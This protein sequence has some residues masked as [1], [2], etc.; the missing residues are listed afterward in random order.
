MFP[1]TAN[2]DSAPRGIFQEPHIKDAA[3]CRA[4]V[5]SKLNG[6]HLAGGAGAQGHVALQY[7]A[8]A[9]EARWAHGGVGSGSSQ[10]AD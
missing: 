3:S 4:R 10:Q 6:E 9:H 1:T 7:H 8:I 5:S 2:V